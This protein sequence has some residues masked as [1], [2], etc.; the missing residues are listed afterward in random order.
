[1]RGTRALFVLW[2]AFLIATLSYTV[3]VG[4]LHK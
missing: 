2:L 3:V 4:A 1:V